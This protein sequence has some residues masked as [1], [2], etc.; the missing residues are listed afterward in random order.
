LELEQAREQ[1]T[2]MI[3]HDLRNPL[4]SMM[5]SLELIQASVLH[6]AESMPLDQVFAVAMRSGRRLYLLID[7]LLDLARLEEGQAN[8]ARQM[9]DV[10]KMLNEILEQIRPV[11]TAHQLQLECRTPDELPSLWGDQDLLQRVVL[12]LL[13]NAIKFTPP[14][15]AVRR[16]VEPSGA[17]ALRFAVSDTGIGIDPEYHDRIF[18]RFARVN[19]SEIQGTG[20]GLALCKLAVE[21]HGGR[22][23]V[24]SVAEEGSI[25]KFVLPIEG[26]MENEE[27]QE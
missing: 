5:S 15:G 13:D 1:L 7:S 10:G 17:D 8:L 6:G 26:S 12:N 23:W 14:G 3:I 9:I 20:L 22:I 27:E 4:S 25:F 2:H 16:A 11:A 19:N 21:A 18:E 24:E